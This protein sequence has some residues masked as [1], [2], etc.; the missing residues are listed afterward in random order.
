MHRN[1]CLNM[2]MYVQIDYLCQILDGCIKGI[3]TFKLR[4]C[5]L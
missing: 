5:M 1:T 3:V 4:I 2:Y